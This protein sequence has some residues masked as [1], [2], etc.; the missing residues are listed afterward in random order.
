MATYQAQQRLFPQ[1]NP[2]LFQ[3]SGN[4][5]MENRR[6]LDYMPLVNKTNI[7]FDSINGNN[8]AASSHSAGNPSNISSQQQFPTHWQQSSHP[9]ATIRRS[10]YISDTLINHQ[11]PGVQQ[12][13]ASQLQQQQSQGFNF[14]NSRFN[15]DNLNSSHLAMNGGT[16]FGN[17]VQSPHSYNNDANNSN[18][19][20]SSNINSQNVAPIQQ[21]RRN[22]QPVASFN[23]N[24][25]TFQQ[26]SR[27]ANTAN[28]FNSERI[29]DVHL[30]E[31]Q[32]SSSVQMCIRD[33]SCM[34]Q[35]GTTFLNYYNL[36][37]N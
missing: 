18:I 16:D 5:I 32:R 23:P 35:E 19:S 10:S 20:N 34:E 24:P 13:Q 12:K 6:G 30:A 31:L 28:I 3:T 25:S 7:G 22:T 14:F 26:Q 37:N 29:E 15:Y 2:N 27:N 8:F 21:F 33:S 4:E 17:G 9:E 36:L 11:M 1:F